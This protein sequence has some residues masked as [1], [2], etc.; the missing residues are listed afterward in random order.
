[1][2]VSFFSQLQTIK[3]TSL[4][5]ETKLAEA[6]LRRKELE[7]EK[8]KTVLERSG[9]ER[10]GRMRSASA[11]RREQQYSATVAKRQAQL[12]EMRDKLKEKHKKNDMIKLKKQLQFGQSPNSSARFDSGFSMQGQGLI[13]GGRDFFDD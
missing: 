3:K 9:L 8:V 11:M 7:E 12:Q 6:E 1:M 5:L 13:N 10:H 2:K 4:K